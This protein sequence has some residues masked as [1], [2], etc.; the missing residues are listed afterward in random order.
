MGQVACTSTV[1]GDPAHGVS[2]ACYCQTQALTLAPTGAPPSP[3][4][5]PTS[6]TPALTLIPAPTPA[7][8][9]VPAPAPKT[10]TSYMATTRPDLVVSTTIAA[11]WSLLANAEQ[12]N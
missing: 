6:S 11:A 7:T 4:L 10:T 1:F 9:P 3:T 12:K 2:K 5:A 8:T